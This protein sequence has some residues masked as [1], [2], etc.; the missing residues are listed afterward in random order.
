[1]S[2]R[3]ARGLGGNIHYHRGS[4]LTIKAG[5]KREAGGRRR[6]AVEVLSGPDP[7]NE[8]RTGLAGWPLRQRPNGC[9]RKR[10]PEVHFRGNNGRVFRTIEVRILKAPDVTP[11]NL[12][13]QPKAELDRYLPII[14]LVVLDVPASFDDLEP[15][16][17]MQGLGRFRDGILHRVLNARVGRTCQ[18]DLFVNVLS[19][20]SLLRLMSVDAISYN[21]VKSSNKSAR[22]KRLVRI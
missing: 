16:Q 12:I 2:D 22:R 11:E 9:G 19:H 13:V 17:I 14:D 15:M 21:Q 20:N 7:W 18:F 6:R 3:V 1:M 8:Q 10:C 4:S 5:P